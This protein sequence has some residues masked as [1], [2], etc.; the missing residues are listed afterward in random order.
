MNY[1]E[2]YHTLNETEETDEEKQATIVNT[3]IIKS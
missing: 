1:Y 2:L 3:L